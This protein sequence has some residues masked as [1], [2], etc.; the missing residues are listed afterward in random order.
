M[1]KAEGQDR[2]SVDEYVPGTS[3]KEA[4]MEEMAEKENMQEQGSHDCGVS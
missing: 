2:P 3:D 1:W 4:M